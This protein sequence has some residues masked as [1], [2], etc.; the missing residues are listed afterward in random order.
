MNKA[1]LARIPALALALLAFPASAAAQKPVPLFN[2]KN[3]DGWVRRGGNAQYH[4][5]GDEI[6][7]ISTLDTPNTFLCTA[8]TYGDFILEYEFKADE[9]LNSGVQIRSECHDMPTEALV[10]GR[11]RKIPAGRV[12]GYQ[13][14]IDPDVPRARMWSAGIYDEARRG[15]LFPKGKQQETAFSELGRSIFKP[16]DWNHV[17]V[18]A[19]GDSIKTWLN[20][21]PCAD[22]I[23]SLT[24]RGFIAL[25]VHEIGKDSKKDGAQVRWRNLV[26]TEFVTPDVSAPNTLTPAEKATGWTLLW[27]G[28][29]PAGWRGAKTGSF[30]AQ[31]WSIK[32]GML[33][34]QENGGAESSGGGDIITRQR[35]TDFELRL[36]FKITPGANSGIKYFVQPNLNP[37]T[38]AGAKASIGSAIGLEYQILDDAHHPDAKLGRDGNRTLGSLYDLITASPDKKPAPTGEWNAA[39]VIVRGNHVEHWLNGKKILE[40]DR[41]TPAFRDAVTGSKYKNIPGFG[42]W[43]DGHILLQE[44]G[45]EVSFR[46][47]KIRVSGK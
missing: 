18:E 47:I 26:I 27:D 30:P 46:N 16:D 14:E 35:Y 2:G 31:G 19:I 3:L 32:N 34:V 11:Q 23:D 1:A 40:Y 28:K 21:A 17:R 33:T 15:W 5:E 7:G 39:R 10:N 22:I 44:H 12:H 42:E 13:I 45:N 37:V 24:P 6:V 20:G 9:R 36:D 38:G 41:G 43:P 25:Q 29:T 4:I 8:K